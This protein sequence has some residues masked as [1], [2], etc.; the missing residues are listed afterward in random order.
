MK[1]GQAE[2]NR[3]FGG[4]A[5]QKRGPD[6]WGLTGQCP[7]VVSDSQEKL[8][9]QQSWGGVYGGNVPL[10]LCSLRLGGKQGSGACG[11]RE[12][13]LKCGQDKAEGE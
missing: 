6:Q 10:S 13:R 12:A 4:A 5:G 8:I 11:K 3:V 7:A 9:K 1:E 2:I